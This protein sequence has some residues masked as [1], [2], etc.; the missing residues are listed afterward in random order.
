MKRE[1][2]AAG[3]DCGGNDGEQGRGKGPEGLRGKKRRCAGEVQEEYEKCAE[4]RPKFRCG[5]SEAVGVEV[6]EEKW[7]WVWRCGGR[8]AAGVETLTGFAERHP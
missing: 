3:A 7:L 1:G 2:T 4:W 8:E 5:E 6:W